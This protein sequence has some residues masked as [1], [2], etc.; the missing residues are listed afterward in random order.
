MPLSLYAAIVPSYLQILESIDRLIGK[1]E[2][3][4]TDK[5]LEPGSIIGAR[6]ADDMLPFAYQVKSVTVHSIGAIEG[7]HQGVFSPDTS[8]LPANFSG[9]AELVRSAMTKLEALDPDE[10]EGFIGRDMRFEFG[11]HR[12]DFAAED[13]L[14]SFSQPN[15]YFHA[16]TAYDILRMLGLNIGKRD[17]N[18]RL[19]KRP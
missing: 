5:N 15:F 18:G 14:L 17:F 7:V 1:A 12:M 10:L 11:T 2:A 19:R 16:A 9:L 4:C 13:F 8:A 6:L 3:F